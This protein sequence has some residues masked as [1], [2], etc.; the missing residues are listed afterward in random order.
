MKRTLGKRILR[1]GAAMVLMAVVL[2]A[3]ASKEQQTGQVVEEE[4][5]LALK[6]KR[7]DQY[8]DFGGKTA[9]GQYVV[10]ELSIKN[11]GLESMTIQPTDFYIQNITSD[12][13][14]QYSQSPEKYMSNPFSKVYGRDM[15]DKLLDYRSSVVHPKLEIDR[16]LIFMLASDAR[17]ET[18]QILHE[19]TGEITPMV[20]EITAVH[21]YRNGSSNW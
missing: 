9:D 17:L 7:V 2:A 5:P 10:V 1:L 3:C 14:E 4:P 18:F 11:D 16:Y 20:T 19:P 21:D 6:V 15:R 12:L 13:S 8:I